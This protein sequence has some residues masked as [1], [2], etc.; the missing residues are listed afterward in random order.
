MNSLE[1][2]MSVDTLRQE[3]I[4]FQNTPFWDR[5]IR[6]TPDKK[7]ASALDVISAVSTATNRRAVWKRKLEKLT[8]R[9]KLW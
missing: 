7:Y 4:N 8:V 1:I 5:V 2:R 9:K 3:T 6:V